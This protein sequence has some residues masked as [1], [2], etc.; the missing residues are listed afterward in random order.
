MAIFWQKNNAHKNG[1]AKSC[2]RKTLLNLFLHNHF[3]TKTQN[4]KILI[5]SDYNTNIPTTE[6]YKQD[7]IEF[8]AHQLA[9]QIITY[10]PKIDLS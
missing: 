5:K 7:Q 1:L 6:T 4:V 10:I 2:Q 3:G 8:A 9:I